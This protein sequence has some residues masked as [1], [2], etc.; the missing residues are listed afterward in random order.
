MQRARAA[1]QSDIYP[2]F[3]LS[4]DHVFAMFREVRYGPLDDEILFR[5]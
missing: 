1:R 4:R 3:W 5:S 2:R